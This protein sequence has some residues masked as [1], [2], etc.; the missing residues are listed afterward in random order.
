MRLGGRAAVTAKAWGAGPR[1][2]GDYAVRPQPADPIIPFICNIEASVSTQGDNGG[3]YKSCLRAR[4]AI[5]HP[6]RGTTAARHGSDY[7]VRPYPANAAIARIHDVEAPIRRYLDI[8]GRIELRLSGRAAITAKAWD[9]GPRNSGKGPV[10]RHPEND[11]MLFIIEV[12]AAVRAHDISRKG[13]TEIFNRI[14]N[15]A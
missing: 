6:I 2:R 8:N 7:A 15:Q 10:R 4:A 9:A 13:C 14:N 5:P 1:H 12:D 3:V 11:V